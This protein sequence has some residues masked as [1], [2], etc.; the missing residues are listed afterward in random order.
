MG[1]PGYMS[2]EQ[3][4]GE[5]ARVDERSDVF[6]LGVVLYELLT[7][8]VPF[9]GA[10][11]EHILERLLS[12]RFRPVRGMCPDAPPELA[13]IAERSLRSE[14]V[15]RYSDAGELAGEL[16]AYHSGGRVQAYQYG[17]W[18]LLR[19]FASSHRALLTGVGIAVGALLVAAG[20]VVARLH[21]ARHVTGSTSG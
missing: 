16:T 5:R 9:G 13:A 17:T 15:G 3:A 14:P 20:V 10:T 18:E 2:P 7:G 8:Q 4:R 19:K 11:A 21:Q 6:S 12:G 1:T